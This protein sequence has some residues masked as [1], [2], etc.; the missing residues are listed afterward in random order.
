MGL[1]HKINLFLQHQSSPDLD[2][3]KKQ[4]YVVLCC[5]FSTS[6]HCVVYVVFTAVEVGDI[7]TT[8]TMDITI[9]AHPKKH[10]P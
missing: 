5:S 6:Q 8:T 10:F 7:I 1:A 3:V 9:L 4:L 2:A